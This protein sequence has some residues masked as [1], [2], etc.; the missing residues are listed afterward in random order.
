MKKQLFSILLLLTG[1]V[2][3]LSAQEAYAVLS[4]DGETITFYYDNQKDNRTGVVEINQSY[5]DPLD[6]WDGQDNAYGTARTAVIDASFADYRPTSTAYWFLW[7]NKLES[8]TGME[9]LNTA[10]V[11]NMKEMFYHCDNLTS[12][13][14]SNFN[15]DKVTNMYEMFG[16]CGRLTTLD[17]SNFNTANVTNMWNMFWGCGALTSLDVSNFDTANVTEMTGM[18]GGCWSLTYLDVSNFNTSNV[19]SMGEMFFSCSLA[20]LDLSNFN[21]DNVTD[22]VGM[23][24]FCYSLT[25]L[26]LSSFNTAN[27]TDMI[28]MFAG[29]NAL[30][31][32]DLSSFNTANVTDMS[33]MFGGCSAL[34]TIYAGENWTTA[35]VTNGENM[36]ANCTALVGGAGTT[37]D[38]AH[39]N[40]A[41]AR[42][43]GGI[44]APG[45]LTD[46]S[47]AY[48]VLSDDG[49]TVTFYYNTKK[50]SRTGVVEINQTE[51]SY[52]KS[53][54]Y[55]TASTAIID[56]SFAD[57]RPTSTAFWFMGCINLTTITG[58]EY[59][60]TSNVTSMY[61][62][63]GNCV[64]L[65]SLDVSNF[66]TGNVKS[67]YG[68]FNN[69]WSLTSLDVSNFNTANV[70]L[71]GRMFGGC[72][73]L[74]TI[75]ASENW[76]TAAVTNGENMFASC[77]ALVGGA[78]TIYNDYY[79]DT[80]YARIDGGVE[81]PGYLTY[82]GVS[83]I[84]TARMDATYDKMPIYNLRGERLAAP[85]K[86]LNIIGRRKVIVK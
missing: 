19:K 68:M 76:T 46:K 16:Y 56:P 47:E 37:Y 60:N 84:N 85:Q 67:M 61:L 34:N 77:T 32:L 38:V 7:C 58:M 64:Y 23:F 49:E 75:Y 79:T 15:T 78:G 20:S 5:I 22:M 18:F 80:S 40:H 13:D 70:T 86:G 12:L 11:T 82:K 25:S 51:T 69:C 6:P 81:A 50:D 33:G 21:T 36:F 14:V 31:S 57:Y 4:D 39:T 1:V 35:A 59:L 65:T 74:K 2:Q 3:T 42:I 62:M 54:V 8:I 9:H 83:G 72:I 53:N 30:T 24:M 63:F 17:V 48:A 73:A 43:D 26:N 10:E 41:Y 66:N 71:M 55:G 28:E 29:C 52:N 27:V 45:Y 44:E